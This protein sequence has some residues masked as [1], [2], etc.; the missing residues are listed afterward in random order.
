M[1]DTVTR[2]EARRRVRFSKECQKLET[3]RDALRRAPHWLSSPD[4]TLFVESQI[5]ILQNMEKRLS[6]KP[7]IA[8]V[9]GSGSGKSTLVSA[10]AGRD[11]CVVSGRQ[12]PT[13]RK[14]TA[15]TRSSADVDQL[16]G[17]LQLDDFTVALLPETRL[18]NAILLDTPDTDSSECQAYSDLL[19][20]TLEQ[21][22]ILLCVFD[23]E[24]PKRKDNLDR[25]STWV[26]RFP[27]RHLFLVLNRCDR[28][29]RDQLVNEVLP[30]FRECVKRYWKGSVEEIFCISARDALRDPGWDREGI[31]PQNRESQFDLL[32]ET[33][34]KL[35]DTGRYIDE[36]VSHAEHI[37]IQTEAL[38]YETLKNYGDWAAMDEALCTFERELY[39]AHL[40]DLVERLG[41]GNSL[42]VALLGGS[43]ADRW[44]GPV[45]TFL[46]FGRRIRNFISPLRYVPMLNP[47]ATASGVAKAFKGLSHPGRAESL[48]EEESYSQ[49]GQGDTTAIRRI[50]AARWPALGDRLVRDFGFTPTYRES[51]NSTRCETLCSYAQEVWPRLL[52]EAVDT[53]S[54][55]LSRGWL[56]WLANLPVIALAATACVYLAIQF[57]QV[58]IFHQGNYCDTNFYLHAA[59]LMVLSWLLPSWLMQSWIKRS[60]NRLP[61]AL[62][63]G[64][65]AEGNAPRVVPVADQV[66][67]L[68]TLTAYLEEQ[69]N[70]PTE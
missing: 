10:L 40:T 14:I 2:D 57:Y 17:H 11:N 5:R 56:Q 47:V 44:W 63:K 53:L 23:I 9:G 24:N 25:L 26:G 16:L 62:M 52:R 6:A 31:H 3:L 36:R 27:A 38:G 46:G 15:V 59:A 66:H 55:R 18:P 64:I 69:E 50:I 4:T 41:N 51:Q 60:A 34:R 61:Q 58:A 8:A 7:V 42:P 33:L 1:A 70:G 39:L 22:D 49:I 32:V 12:R 45:G 48:L 68:A 67:A 29:P 30:D 54:R 21:A 28:I 37:R 13:T 19:D 65:E 43:V 35:G 20:L